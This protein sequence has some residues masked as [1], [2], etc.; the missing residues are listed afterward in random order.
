MQS[1]IK[2]QPT[3]EQHLARWQKLL[4]DPQLAKLPYKI[5]TDRFGRILMSPPPFFDHARYVAKIIELLHGLL[6][7]GKAFAETPVLT[8]DGVKVTDAAWFSADYA[9]EL[10]GQHPTA[11]ERAPEICV[12]VL[13]SSNTP[14]E[15]AEKRALYFDAGAQEVWLCEF[16]GK[17]AFY[18]PDPSDQSAICSEF[19][20]QI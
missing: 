2:L 13:S 10:E 11:L 19:P 17:I 5:E 1:E 14:E 18:M 3:P 7:A 8:S 4:A 9:H 12:E 20:S 6:P 15:M 16:D